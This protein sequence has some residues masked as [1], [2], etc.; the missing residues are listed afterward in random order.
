[1]R[2]MLRLLWRATGLAPVLHTNHVLD[3]PDVARRGNVTMASLA[4]QLPCVIAL[5]PLDLWAKNGSELLFRL[6]LFNLQSNVSLNASNTKCFSSVSSKIIIFQ[7]VKKNCSYT[8]T[9][10]IIY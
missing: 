7:N 8:N 5:Q 6:N 9:L 10:I 3:E 2:N 4:L 1:M